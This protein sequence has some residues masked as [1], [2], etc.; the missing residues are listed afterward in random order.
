MIVKRNFPRL[1]R[2]FA[3]LSCLI[4]LALQLLYYF[5]QKHKSSEKNE[6]VKSIINQVKLG[7]KLQQIQQEVAKELEVIH[8]NSKIIIF[9]PTT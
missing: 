5:E 6:E 3:I 8:F 9:K 4:F 1:I 7:E 2:K